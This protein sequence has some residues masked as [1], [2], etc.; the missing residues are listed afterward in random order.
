M[1]FFRNNTFFATNKMYF[2]IFLDNSSVIRA[3]VE[4]SSKVT[5]SISLTDKIYVLFF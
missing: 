2:D 1:F 3:V 5:I 4:C